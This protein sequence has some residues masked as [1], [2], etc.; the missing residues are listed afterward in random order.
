MV[1]FAIVM[2]LVLF[3][4]LGV[5]Q[6]C[7]LFSARAVLHYASYAAARSELVGEDPLFSATLI[8]SAIAGPTVLGGG[9]ADINIPGWGI[10]PRSR[11]SASKT[12]VNVTEPLSPE[13][14]RVSVEVE[15]DVELLF[16]EIV[17]PLLGLG[18]THNSFRQQGATFVTFKDS[19]T[20]PKNWSGI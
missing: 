20:L 1:E 12:R 17:M 4:T 2:P 10:L 3:I 6:L 15:H 16:P 11:A 8:C 9:Y 7:L 5:L 18:K 14:E 19:F 13:A